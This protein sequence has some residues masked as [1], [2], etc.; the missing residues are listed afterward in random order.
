MMYMLTTLFARHTIYSGPEDPGPGTRGP[1]DPGTRGPGTGDPGTQ[2]PGTGD[3]R[4]QGPED[5]QLL[6]ETEMQLQ[7]ICL[8]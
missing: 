7:A 4:T 8:Y 5:L 1:G 3:P 6:R 2:G